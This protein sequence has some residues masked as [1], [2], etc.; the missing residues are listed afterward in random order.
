VKYI[1]GFEIWKFGFD[2][3]MKI[4]RNGDTWELQG[5]L[6]RLLDVALIGSGAIATSLWVTRGATLSA[7]HVALVAFASA[8]ALLWFPFVGVYGSWRGRAKRHLAAMVITGW[9]LALGSAVALTRALGSA[10]QVSGGWIAG[11]AC[12]VAAALVM[13][14][15]LVHT[16]LARLRRAGRDLRYVAIVGSGSHCE[17]ILRNVEESPASGFRVV[18]KLDVDAKGNATRDGVI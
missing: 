11:W 17:N 13:S 12:L 7:S 9:L 3:A 18:M 15:V 6:T 1:D 5:A 8:S 10:E 14:R 16:V 4:F 2:Y